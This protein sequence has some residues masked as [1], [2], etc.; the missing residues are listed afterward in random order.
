MAQGLVGRAIPCLFAIAAF[1]LLGAR[2]LAAQDGESNVFHEAET[3]PWVDLGDGI[4][5]ATLYGDAQG[6]G[7][8]AFRLSVPDGFAMAPHTHPVVE[9]MT[10]LA[11]RFFVGLGEAEDRNAATGYG[12]GSYI[13]VGA[14]VPAYMWAEGPTIVQVHGTGPMTTTYLEPG[15]PE[16]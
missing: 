8:F 15:G 2:G 7:P 5:R 6:E 3:L 14:G 12:P 9:H 16:R 10:V 4:R 11:G 13:A 1:S